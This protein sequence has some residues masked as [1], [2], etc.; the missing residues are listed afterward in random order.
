[1][2][3]RKKSGALQGEREKGKCDDHVTEIVFQNKHLRAFNKC[4]III[5]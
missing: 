5:D 3:A 2:K 4:F 1:M